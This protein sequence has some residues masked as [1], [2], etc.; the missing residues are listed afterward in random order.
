VVVSAQNSMCR[1][2]WNSGSPEAHFRP[3]PRVRVAQEELAVGWNAGFLA[4]RWCLCMAKRTRNVPGRSCHR[5]RNEF[6]LPGPVRDLLAPL[7]A[8]TGRRIS[9]P[10][11]EHGGIIQ[12]PG[13]T[14][15]YRAIEAGNPSFRVLLVMLLVE[16]PLKQAQP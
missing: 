1:S 15:P 13:D 10:G 8:G 3:I 16:K 4:R 5:L 2:A 9:E 12:T 11:E 7:R 6:D 14:G